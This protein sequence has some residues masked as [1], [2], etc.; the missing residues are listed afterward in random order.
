LINKQ[1]KVD[2]STKHNRQQWRRSQ[3]VRRKPGVALAL[4]KASKHGLERLGP[5]KNKFI[6]LNLNFFVTKICKKETS[7]IMNFIVF[8]K[9]EHF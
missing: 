1:K 5:S 8:Y 9:K 6:D 2:E 7:F 4:H 3:E